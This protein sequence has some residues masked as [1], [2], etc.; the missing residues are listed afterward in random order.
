[1]EIFSPEQAREQICKGLASY[2]D[3][4][5]QKAAVLTQQ[6]NYVDELQIL[7]VSLSYPLHAAATVFLLDRELAGYSFSHNSH[8]GV[9]DRMQALI[10]CI[11]DPVAITRAQRQLADVFVRGVVLSSLEDTVRE[12]LRLLETMHDPKS[13]YN[14]HP[15]VKVNPKYL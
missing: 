1:M 10:N 8:N 15:T 3:I 5:W 11:E 2:P 7:G 14:V 12:H 4:G 13:Q 6:F 9:P